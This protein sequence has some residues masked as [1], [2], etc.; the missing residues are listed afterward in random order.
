MYTYTGELQK[1]LNIQVERL[2]QLDAFIAENAS[3][4]INW[5]ELRAKDPGR[6]LLERDKQR[7]NE[8][9]RDSIRRQQQALAD[10]QEM[11][12]VN[13]IQEKAKEGAQELVRYIPELK[14]PEKAKVILSDFVRVAG[15]FGYSPKEVDEVVDPR[16][17]RVLHAA[18][19]W[20]NHVGKQKMPKPAA[21]QL[22]GMDKNRKIQQALL[23]KAK[24][25]GKVDDIAALLIVDRKK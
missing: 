24:S 11:L 3:P 17:M 23:N 21:Q 12:N 9:R 14:D 15:E 6:Y 7:E 2:K 19:Q 8:A 16:A 22:K 25:S 1:N 5:D 4:N 10:Q 18:V 20:M 13:I